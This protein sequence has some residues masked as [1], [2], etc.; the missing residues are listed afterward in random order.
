MPLRRMDSGFAVSRRAG[1][2][3]R[4]AQFASL[5]E[6]FAALL[7]LLAGFVVAALHGKVRLPLF[8]LGPVA[9]RVAPPRR[10]EIERWKLQALPES[11]RALHELAPGQRQRRIGPGHGGVDEQRGRAWRLVACNEP[12]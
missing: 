1:M 6:P 9:E 4:T 3:V 5:P 10:F 7:L 8:L 2:T 11:D 12:A